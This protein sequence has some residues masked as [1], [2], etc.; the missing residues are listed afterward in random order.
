MKTIASI[1]IFFCSILC[2]SENQ[3]KLISGAKVGDGVSFF[4]S[5]IEYQKQLFL[6]TKGYVRLGGASYTIPNVN[7]G[8]V[9]A[10][11]TQVSLGARAYVGSLY[12]G[13]GYEYNSLNLYHLSSNL[14][15]E[16]SFSGPTIEVGNEFEFGPIVTAIS[17]GAQL[18]AVNLEFSGGEFD[19]GLLNDGQSIFTKFE[20]SIG[21]LF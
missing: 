18:A 2:F 8:A 19:T 21:Y 10:E 7:S 5:D 11:V 6:Q 9:T 16:G 14:N 12:L 4:L 17:I 20:C 1:L 13:M 3:L 15:A